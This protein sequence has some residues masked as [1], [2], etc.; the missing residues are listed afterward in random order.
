[1]KNEVTFLYRIYVKY[2]VERFRSLNKTKK[3]NGNPQTLNFS[4]RRQ[5]NGRGAISST[6]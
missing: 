4:M 6:K 1:M 2:A 3:K 5:L